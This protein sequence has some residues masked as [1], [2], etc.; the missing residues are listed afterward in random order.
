MYK[1][2]LEFDVLFCEVMVILK[3]S[4]HPQPIYL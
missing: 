2:Y 4:P 3:S 1:L